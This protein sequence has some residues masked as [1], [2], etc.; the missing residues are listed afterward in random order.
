MDNLLTLG[1][2]NPY[3]AATLFQLPTPLTRQMCWAAGTHPSLLTEALLVLFN[4]NL[5]PTNP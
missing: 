4:T 5:S 2:S 1:V 3:A